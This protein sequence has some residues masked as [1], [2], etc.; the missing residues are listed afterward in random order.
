MPKKTVVKFNDVRFRK[1]V[2]SKLIIEQTK[3]LERYAAQELNQMATSHTFQNKTYNL[4]DS[5]VWGV[6]WEGNLRSYGFYGGGRAND[7]SYLHE[8]SRMPIPVNGRQEAE[9]F[10]TSYRPSSN[11]GWEVVW[12]AAAPYSVYLDEMS[13]H[14]SRTNRFMV[15]SQRYDHIK[16]V[17]GNKGRVRFETIG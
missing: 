17:F 7:V 10:I 16:Q 12:A 8:W 1:R 3:R 14:Q 6:F 11:N 13:T 15:I 4:Q 2:W 9:T 5:Y